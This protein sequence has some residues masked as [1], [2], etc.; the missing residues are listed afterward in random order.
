MKNFYNN[1]VVLITGGTGSFG[2]M[3]VKHLIKNFKLK[4][5]IVLSR[6]ELKQFEMQQQIKDKRV[7]YFIG[8]IRD[9]SRLKFALKDV[10][11]VFHAAALKQVPAAEYNPIECIN[12]N[13]YGTENLIKAAIECKVKK[14][15]MLSTDKAVNPINLYGATKLCAEK[16]FINANYLAVPFH[17]FFYAEGSLFDGTMVIGINIA[18]IDN[19]Q[20]SF[21]LF[22]FTRIVFVVFY[23]L[24][25][26][27]FGL[28]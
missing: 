1:K 18:F 25:K 11:Y 17:G 27:A 26:N 9:Y 24:M 10:D 12:T 21:H 28:F 16:L 22:L 13:V 14:V 19:F 15:L 4:K 7:R 5:I 23:S 8:D 6:D 2:K 3:C 20:H